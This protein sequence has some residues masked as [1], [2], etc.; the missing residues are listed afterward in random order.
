MVLR[1][2]CLGMMYDRQRHSFL[3]RLLRTPSE[4][5][6]EVRARGWAKADGWAMASSA[7]SVVGADVIT[8]VTVMAICGAAL[9]RRSPDSRAYVCTP[10]SNLPLHIHEAEE[11]ACSY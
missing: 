10:L 1:S 2:C 4:L 7:I 9:H 8:V 11:L 3:L 6:A 5:L